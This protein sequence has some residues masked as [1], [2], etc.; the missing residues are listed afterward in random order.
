VQNKDD[1]SLSHK[2]SH[3][4]RQRTVVRFIAWPEGE[5]STLLA[6]SVS[7]EADVLLGRWIDST[8]SKGFHR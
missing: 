3:G 5:A 2:F 6:S 8:L 1:W 7:F 4:V